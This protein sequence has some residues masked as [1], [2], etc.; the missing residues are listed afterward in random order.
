M[1]RDHR[2][3]N[4]NSLAEKCARIAAIEAEKAAARGTFG[5]GGLLIENRTGKVLK[6]AA[7]KVITERKDAAIDPTAHVEKQLVDWYY[8][9]YC[10]HLPKKDDD[11]ALPLSPPL[12]A[13]MTIVCSLDPCIMCT[14]A[15]LGAGLNMIRISDDPECGVSCRGH[16]DLT[17]LP[18]GVRQE[19]A[20]RFSAF[21]LRGK[22]P[23]AGSQRS[24]FSGSEIDPIFEKRSTRAFKAGLDK[25]RSCLNRDW[26]TLGNLENPRLLAKKED[27]SSRS[28]YLVETFKRYN[29]QVFSEKHILEQG[30]PGIALG[31][32]LI[33]KAKESSTKTGVFNS[34]CIID[35]FGNILLATGANPA[36]KTPLLDIMRGYYSLANAVGEEG[37]RYLAHP[38]HCKISILFGPTSDPT[39]LMEV[40]ALGSFFEG[41]LPENTSGQ[42]EYIIPRQDSSRLEGMLRSLPPFYSE[43]VDLPKAIRQTQDNA[44]RELCEAR[45]LQSA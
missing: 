45:T 36:K 5:V 7:N 23:F 25:V 31:Q 11:A 15:I 3:S 12:D 20:A 21:G 41:K 16:D 14:G 10:C 29:P 24:I 18:E 42:L 6:R 13:G 38:K 35:P 9:H 37:R 28:S 34:A 4:D 39:G 44:L 2:S 32:M 40:G 22:R 17:T 19:K 8:Y 27:Y 26:Q 43:T 30:M 1:G 33:A